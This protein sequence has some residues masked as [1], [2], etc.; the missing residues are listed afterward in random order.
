MTWLEN[1]QDNQAPEVYEEKRNAL[2]KICS[3]I[4]AKLYQGGGGAP[5]GMPGGG[6][7][8]A[9]G[10]GGAGPHVEEVD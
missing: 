7:G 1:N 6:M 2:E 3:P 5:G 8:G 9:G 4:L 10:A